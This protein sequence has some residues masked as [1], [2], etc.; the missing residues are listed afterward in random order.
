[1]YLILKADRSTKNIIMF[2]NGVEIIKYLTVY[3]GYWLLL[4]F[5]TMTTVVL[6][7]MMT[8]YGSFY[9]ARGV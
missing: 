4:I 7:I 5:V 6:P 1:M 9:T 3:I 8:G 2:V